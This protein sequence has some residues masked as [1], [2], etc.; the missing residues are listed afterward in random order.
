M[1]AFRFSSKVAVT[2]AAIGPP[3]NARQA[4]PQR[5]GMGHPGEQVA[6][7]PVACIKLHKIGRDIIAIGLVLVGRRFGQ[8]GAMWQAR[9]LQH[10]HKAEEPGG[11]QNGIGL[12][13][14]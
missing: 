9:G 13:I 8:E 3:H 4:V 5:R 7:E 12:S 11:I 1:L 6:D 2:S 10:L 14:R